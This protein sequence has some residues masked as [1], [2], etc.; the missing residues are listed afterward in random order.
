MGAVL[1]AA[2]RLTTTSGLARDLHG[3]A[4]FF[5]PATSPAA[6]LH[7]LDGIRCTRLNARYRAAHTWPASSCA[8]A[9]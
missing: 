4:E 7:A 6:A 2:L 9:V 8:A 3:V 5:P 1:R